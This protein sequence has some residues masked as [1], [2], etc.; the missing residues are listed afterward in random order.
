MYLKLL[1]VRG[2]GGSCNPA[3]HAVG[4]D[5]LTGDVGAVPPLSVSSCAL[6]LKRMVWGGCSPFDL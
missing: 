4:Y 3:S 1:I 2:G 5:L 6:I